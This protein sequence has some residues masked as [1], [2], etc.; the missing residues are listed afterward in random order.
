MTSLLFE[1]SR[2]HLLFEL[3]TQ[4]DA[5]P[6]RMA[7]MLTIIV[8]CG[9]FYGAVLGSWHGPKLSLYVAAKIPMLLISTAS[10]LHCSTTS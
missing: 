6:R 8:A 4:S 10:S 3:T 9:A 7:L 5:L 1:Q 2:R